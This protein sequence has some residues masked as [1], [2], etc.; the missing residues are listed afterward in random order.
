MKKILVL[1][2]AFIL[3]ISA[4]GQKNRDKIQLKNGSMIYGQVVPLESGDIQIKSAGNI[5]VFKNS[6]VETIIYGYKKTKNVDEELELS[7]IEIHS[8]VGVLAGNGGN[9]QSA[10][11]IFQTSVNYNV[12]K[13]LSLGLGSGIE[14]LNETYL[15][16]FANIEYKLRNTKF[17]PYAFVQAGY[18]FSVDESRT[19]GDYIVPYYY[20]Y[21]SSFYYPGPWYNS[22]DMDA[23]G[24]LLINPGIGIRTMFS[25]NFG[26]SFSFGYRYSGLKYTG[27][28]DYTIWHDYNRLSL[29]L[30][31]IFN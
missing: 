3:T 30:G 19:Q 28:S 18:V 6:E 15:P 21:S 8:E 4:S 12:N 17:S 5:W 27:E 1:V 23:K 22:A 7:K 25:E 10:P 13:N 29:K 11:F 16:V 20:Y 2:A 31:I 24:G 9:P 14:Y 26:M